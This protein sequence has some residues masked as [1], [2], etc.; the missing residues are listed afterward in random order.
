MLLLSACSSPPRLAVRAA[1]PAA[2]A[3]A[4]LA[5]FFL[6]VLVLFVLRA[7]RVLA[8]EPARER[9]VLCQ[10]HTHHAALSSAYLCLR[11]VRAASRR[12]CA[13]VRCGSRRS[14]ALSC[15]L[16]ALRLLRLWAARPPLR[17][18][19]SCT[20]CSSLAGLLVPRVCGLVAPAAGLLLVLRVLL[21]P[22]CLAAR[23]CFVPVRAPHAVACA[24][25]VRAR[26]QPGYLGVVVPA[27]GLPSLRLCPL[28]SL[29]GA[30]AWQPPIST[31]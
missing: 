19:C 25:G 10:T 20:R 30:A 16:P 14:A 15:G 6:F 23:C 1:G 11:S 18:S 13:C 22:P 8:C 4:V 5:V 9:C 29:A 27:S 21:G 3:G 7:A 12:L 2:S 28:A 17:A 26:P 31:R 24:C